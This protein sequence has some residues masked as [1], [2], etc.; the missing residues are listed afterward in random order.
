MFVREPVAAPLREELAKNIAKLIQATFRS[1][2][3]PSQVPNPYPNL[4]L[5]FQG[6]LL[7]RTLVK[8]LPTWLNE[9]RAGIIEDL[10]FFVNKA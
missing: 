4:E 1:P 8:F 7:T 9:N 10:F 3:I 2:P 6:I 5:Q